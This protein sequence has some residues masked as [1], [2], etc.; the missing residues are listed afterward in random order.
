MAGTQ[1]RSS[2]L[3]HDVHAVLCCAV[4]GGMNNGDK[5]K[6]QSFLQSASARFPKSLKLTDC[7]LSNID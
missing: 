4:P 3:F 5:E 2:Q 1:T 7:V 6:D